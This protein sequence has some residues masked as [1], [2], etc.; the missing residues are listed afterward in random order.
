MVL[1]PTATPT[2]MSTPTDTPTLTAT[3]TPTIPSW[4]MT[5][6]AVFAAL[7]RATV[8]TSAT[9]T[10]LVAFA[11]DPAL[12]PD[13]R[14]LIEQAITLGRRFYGDVPRISVYTSSTS[15]GLCDSYKALAIRTSCPD[16]EG[17]IAY[18][19]PFGGIFVLTSADSWR[20]VSNPLKI[21]VVIHEYV[22][23]VQYHLAY[24]A[25]GGFVGNFGP[26]WLDEGS[27]DL[28]ALRAVESERLYDYN[29]YAFGALVGS[30][31]V[32]APLSQLETKAGATLAGK[33]SE[34]SLGFKA[35]EYLE[36]DYGGRPAILKFFG[37]LNRGDTWKGAFVDA[38]GISAAQFYDR[39]EEYR[40]ANFPPLP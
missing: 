39:F 5:N 25:G 12:A 14:A 3:A 8:T 28:L 30:R 21:H 20:Q 38:F 15:S 4:Q 23:L 7:A 24:P 1:S 29:A 33:G 10:P 32:S 17:F 19:V 40:H 27:A 22:H 11:Y 2:H 9:P 26:L 18:A 36:K 16:V 13:Q 35:V 31:A 6:T 34:Y 37:R